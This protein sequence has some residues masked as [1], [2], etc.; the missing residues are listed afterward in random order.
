MLKSKY[1]CLELKRNLADVYIVDSFVTLNPI[2]C[3]RWMKSYK[4][5]LEFYVISF[6]S[7]SGQNESER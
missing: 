1:N 7:F 2:M 3:S 5:L 6:L 4:L